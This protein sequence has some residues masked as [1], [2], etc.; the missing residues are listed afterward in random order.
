MEEFGYIIVV[1]GFANCVLAA[2][3][4]E[5]SSVVVCVLESGLRDH[6]P[7]IPIPVGWMKLMRDSKIN[8]LYE[9]DPSESTSGRKKGVPRGKVISGSSSING[10][11]FNRGA[12]TDFDHWAQLGNQG[13]SYDDILPLFR[14]M[15]TWLPEAET[16]FRGKTG[17]L[18]VT[19]SDWTHPLCEA[20]LDS[21]ESIG[22]PRNLDYNGASQFGAS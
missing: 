1:A 4:A 21:A 2:R 9:T 20:F 11:V 13:W 6:N 16:V 5:R 15:E 14:R 7:L 12:P 19:P 10:N 8:W 18:R 22:M 17:P 3:L